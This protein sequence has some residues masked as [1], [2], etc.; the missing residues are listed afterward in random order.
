VKLH[1]ILQLTSDCALLLGERGNIL[2]ATQNVIE[3]TGFSKDRIQNKNILYLDQKLNL[4]SI[5]KLFKNSS[6]AVLQ[7]SW[8]TASG[9]ETAVQ[10]KS[11]PISHN[12]NKYLLWIITEAEINEHSPTAPLKLSTTQFNDLILYTWDL[13]E[14]VFTLTDKGL[15]F[16]EIEKQPTANAFAAFS[17]QFSTTQLKQLR[18]L[19]ENVV[20]TRTAASK[21]VTL[22]KNDSQLDLLLHFKPWDRQQHVKKIFGTLQLL[23][24]L[25]KNSS[26]SPDWLQATLDKL[27]TA[28]FLMND[29]GKFV[30]ANDMACHSLRY[31]Q[32]ELLNELDIYKIDIETSVREWETHRETLKSEGQATFET[33]L[34]RKDQTILFVELHL[35]FAEMADKKLICI[36]ATDISK[37][38]LEKAQLE[39]SL[40]ETST[41]R[42][43]LKLN[44]SLLESSKGTKI[45]T[46]DKKYVQVLNQANQVALTDATVLILGETGTGKE[47][48]ADLIHQQ[49][50][51][52]EMPFIKVNCA[53]L[54]TELIESELFGHE[55]GAF[56]SADRKKLGRFEIA[57]NGTLFL[58]EIG[59][60]PLSVQPKLLRILQEGEFERLGG[61]ETINVDVRIICATN[62]NLYNMVTKGNFRADLYYRINIFPIENLPLRERK[63]DIPLLVDHFLSKFN[64]KAGKSITSV[65]KKDIELL[66]EYKFPGNVRELEN[67]IERSVILTQ[68]KTLNLSHW[69][70]DAKPEERVPGE[71]E[72]KTLEEIQRQHI[73][74]TLEKTGWRVTGPHGAARLLGLKDRTL[75]SKMRKLGVERPM[76]R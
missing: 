55:K 13:N 72:F 25:E 8:I 20:A 40:I 49:S 19:A 32:T 51:R 16:F 39:T 22:H 53:A 10:I 41:L 47:L 4:I 1:E 36:T 34:Q 45:I 15:I 28:V 66:K 68:G 24:A 42:H 11:Q 67:I 60:L 50:S 52:K 58:D 76:K 31:S 46:K 33:S 7:R 62:R 64:K 69:R 71:E 18:A 27:P 56:T 57:D 73:I 5:R 29:T 23:P 37:R 9:D 75:Q 30:Y 3:I 6:P 35:N 17:R 21:I 70:S 48:L 59:E 14:D 61:T 74:A 43:Q 63:S 2:D 26:A 44:E 65:R 38:R 12:S 54:S